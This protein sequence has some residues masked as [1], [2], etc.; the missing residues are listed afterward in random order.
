MT[1]KILMQPSCFL[2]LWTAHQNHAKIVPVKIETTG[3]HVFEFGT[4][5]EA[6][7]T[8]LTS[9]VGQICVD[10]ISEYGAASVR[11]VQQAVAELLGAA[12]LPYNLNLVVVN[13][14]RITLRMMILLLL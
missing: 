9:Q 3:D 12:T 8:D 6:F 14:I 13:G 4:R 10:T 1:K 7:K 11:D 5:A 2:E